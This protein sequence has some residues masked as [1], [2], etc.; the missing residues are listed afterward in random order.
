MWKQSS[1]QNGLAAYL[2]NSASKRI[3]GNG[4]PRIHKSKPLPKPMFLL[5]FFNECPDYL[6]AGLNDGREGQE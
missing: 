3:I 2:Q 5:P 4:M 1:R 6:T